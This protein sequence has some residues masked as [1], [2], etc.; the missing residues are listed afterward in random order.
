METIEITVTPSG[1]ACGVEVGG[2]DAS[3]PLDPH[4]VATLREAWLKHLVLVLRG[5]DLGPDDQKR[6]C[7]YFGQVGAYHRP[8]ERQNPNYASDTVML[9]SNIRE[10]GQ[11]IGALP[12]GE[13]MWHSDTAYNER[14]HMATTLFAVEV[15]TIGGN[16]L[17]AN[18][19]MA[20]EALPERLKARLKGA[21]A[22]NAYEFGTTIKAELRYEREKVPHFIHPVCR[23][24]PETGRTALFVNELM[25]EEIVGFPEEESR[26]I[27]DELFAIQSR[28]EFVYT[29]R[30]QPGDFVMWDNR[31]S[32]H[33]RTDFPRDQRRLLRRITIE[34]PNPVLVA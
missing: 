3:K 10:N 11:P 33:A 6:L 18:Q 21:M 19:Y 4:T 5:Q 24:H 32:L 22:M 17:F 7:G 25:S 31:C 34:D 26:A 16:T 2:V 29:H 1:A 12:D 20:Y 23:K 8:R 30:W 15:P 9:V 27:L 28:P 13:M 14:P